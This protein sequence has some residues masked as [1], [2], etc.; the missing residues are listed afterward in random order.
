M[1]K[2]LSVILCIA[3]FMSLAAMFTSCS[4]NSADTTTAEG[5][6]APTTTTADAKTTTAEIKKPDVTTADGSTVEIPESLTLIAPYEQEW[7]YKVFFCPYSSTAAGG[8]YDAEQDEFEKFYLDHSWEHDADDLPNGLIDEMKEWPTVV[9]PF[10]DRDTG[11]D[12]ADIGWTGDNHGLMLYTTFNIDNLEEFKK[13][14]ANFEIWVWFDNTPTFYLNGK[15]IFRMDTNCTG[16]PGDWVDTIT[17]I[18][19]E[20]VKYAEYFADDITT[21]NDIFSYLVE[22]ENTLVVT[23]KDAWGG[24]EFDLEMLVG[25]D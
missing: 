24:R 1:K 18:D 22:G 2:V 15:K 6:E 23:L 14:Y 16:N 3:M 10:G 19:P 20:D 4:N 7:H 11:V 21:A 5:T 13:N 12:H 25:N 17:F 8:T 9:G